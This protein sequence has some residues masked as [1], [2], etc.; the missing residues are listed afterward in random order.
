MKNNVGNVGMGTN[1]I[2]QQCLDL[3]KREDVKREMKILFRPILG[4]ILSEIY[5]YI[6]VTLALVFTM[7]LITIIIL[8]LLIT[9]LRNKQLW[10][11]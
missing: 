9:S 2:V 5:P 4:F 11:K 7:F 10:I 3:L 8:V 1:L 6:Y